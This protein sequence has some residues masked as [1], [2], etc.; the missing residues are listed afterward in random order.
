MCLFLF[1]KKKEQLKEGHDLIQILALFL[2]SINIVTTCLE[3]DLFHFLP[4]NEWQ[5]LRTLV[6]LFGFCN[7]LDGGF[8]WPCPLYMGI[9]FSMDL[10]RLSLK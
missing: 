6:Y 1:R 2:K 7:S 3:L 5:L 10:S 8:E 4:K 9:S